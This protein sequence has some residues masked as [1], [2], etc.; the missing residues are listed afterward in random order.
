MARF[1]ATIKG[2]RGE[3]SRLGTAKSGLVV[4]VNGWD[5]GVHIRANVEDGQD[6]IR[7]YKTGGS[8]GKGGG[9][10]LLDTVEEEDG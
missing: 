5:V 9:T 8:N 2:A 7:V 10:W 4:D 6:V 1:R 3:V